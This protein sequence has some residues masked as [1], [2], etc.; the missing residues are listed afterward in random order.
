MG[1]VFYRSGNV[2]PYAE[3]NIWNDPHAAQAVLTA[4]WPVVVHGLDI[5]Y[6]ISF[7]RPFLDQLAQSN[8]KVGR[9]LRDA[10]D[11][12]IEFYQQQ[13]N[14]SGC[15]P[16][17]LLAVV[18]ASNPQWFQ[19]EDAAFEV[20]TSGEEIGRTLNNLKDGAT[21]PTGHKKIALKVDSDALLADYL[22]T[23]SL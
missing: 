15:C 3:A 2:S 20:I 12:Y 7:D 22:Q 16:H 21:P 19:L 17:D 13:H 23:L 5:T 4:P 14:F 18:Y 9:F 8:P 6:Q 1:G 10:A 11:F